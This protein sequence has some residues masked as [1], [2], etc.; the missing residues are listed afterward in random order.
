MP[1]WEHGFKSGLVLAG[2]GAVWCLS[3]GQ[4]VVGHVEMFRRREHRMQ[5][6]WPLLTTLQL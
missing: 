6:R 4:V 1:D 2:H 3:I 5:E